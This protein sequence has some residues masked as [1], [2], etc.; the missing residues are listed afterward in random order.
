MTEVTLSVP[1]KRYVSRGGDK[2]A[3]VAGAFQLN[4]KDTVVLDVGSSTGGFTHFALLHGARQIYAVDSGS[5][6]LDPSLR[7]NPTIQLYE[8]TDIRSFT[9]PEPI[10]IV[11][12]DVS[13]TSIRPILL[14]VAKIATPDYLVVAMVKPQFEASGMQKVRGVVKNERMRRDI[15]H[16]FE[17][18]VRSYYF[19]QRKADSRVAGRKGNRERFFL[20]KPLA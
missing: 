2:L 7:G 19:V 13:F 5:Q 15:L 4:F 3:S 1:S 10:D 16:D 18:W 11:L 8:K 14:Y 6:Q 12:I 17:L 20:L 9:P